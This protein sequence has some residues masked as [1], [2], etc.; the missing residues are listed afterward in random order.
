MVF[1]AI[2]SCTLCGDAARGIKPAWACRARMWLSRFLGGRSVLGA[3]NF[4][5]FGVLGSDI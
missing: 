4:I 3:G 5:W 1:F 2:G